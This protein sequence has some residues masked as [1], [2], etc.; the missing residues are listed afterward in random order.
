MNDRQLKEESDSSSDKRSPSSSFTESLTELSPEEIKIFTATHW[1][2]LAAYMID[3]LP[4][5]LFGFLFL[6]IRF[7]INPLDFDSL[8]AFDE[9]ERI[10]YRLNRT[11]ARLLIS[12]LF[13]GYCAIMDSEYVGQTIGK[14]IMG[15]RVLDYVTL[16]PISFARCLE[17]S[18][19]KLIAWIGVFWSFTPERRFLH[20]KRVDTIVVKVSRIAI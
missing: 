10:I 7:N 15:I 8:L 11:W 6:A 1:Q 17:R 20:D 13:M 19:A 9:E 18:F 5:V 12:V 2:R 4:F 3:V 14:R 16:S